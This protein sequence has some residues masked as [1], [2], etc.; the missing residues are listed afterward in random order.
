MF[1]WLKGLMGVG[2][3]ASTSSAERPLREAAGKT[4]DEEDHG[5]RRLSGDGRR[6]LSPMTQHR[7]REI[8]YYLW[9]ANPLGN[10]CIELPLAYMLA[11]GV[12]L[13]CDDPEAQGWLTAW[14]RDPINAM[15]TQLPK[16]LRELALYGEQCWPVFVNE[17]SGHCRLG[18]LDPADIAEVVRD[19]DNA[20]MVIGI[21]TARDGKGRYRKY[22]TVVAGRDEELFTERTCA[23][24]AEFSDGECFYASV[25]DLQNGNGHGDLLPLSDWIDS[26]D[27]YLWSDLE[28]IGDTRSY[29][30]DVTLAGATPEEVDARAKRITPPRPG[31]VRVHN[32]RESWAAVSPDLRAA[33]TAQTGRLYRNHVLGGSTIPEHWFGGGGDVNRATGDS[34]SD[35]TFKVFAMRQ[36]CAAVLLVQMGTYV[37]TRRYAAQHGRSLDPEESAWHVRCEFPEMVARDITRYAGALQQVTSAAASGISEGVMSKD[38]GIRLIAAIAERMGVSVDL[39]S[40]RDA[41]AAAAEKEAD[42]IAGRP[43]L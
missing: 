22:R 27:Q 18:Y 31:S 12:K 39:D 28:R 5:W 2:A 17:I 11:E 9:R 10:R 23:I 42:M 16:M 34:M 19:P 37:V 14:W 36:Q 40:E 29:V 8:S 25:N 24:R 6:D 4:I 35:P 3:G 21:V 41:L 20:R 32:D 7:M 26:Y 13:T 15:D 43:Q 1:D 38:L 33:D 30:W